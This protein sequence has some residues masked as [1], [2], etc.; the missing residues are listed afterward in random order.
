MSNS[1][2]PR[3]IA[4]TIVRNESSNYLR[5]W[6]ENIS[7]FADYH[8]F[9]DDASDDSTPDIIKEH[10]KKYPGELHI[11]KTPLFIKNEPLLRSELWDYTRRVARQGDWILIVDADE[12]YD[13]TLLRLK[14]KLLANKF[15]NIDVVKV[16]CLDMW[17]STSFRKDGYWSPFY[18]A[19][20]LIRFYDVDFGANNTSLHMPAYP[21]STDISKNL[22]KFVP[23]MHFAYLRSADRLRRYNF[24]KSNVS[25]D[26]N[27]TAYMHALS[28]MAPNPKTRSFFGVLSCIYH[29]MMGHKIYMQIY[30]ELKKYSQEDKNEKDS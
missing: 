25:P 3:L 14:P 18:T 19:V 6:L 15:P 23:M 26:E 13:E 27:K 11:R 1:Y 4:I 10:L 22:R 9:V 29:S 12:F 8:I 16:S 28:I 2:N 7:N 24:Y 20:R 5:S 17:N 21:S 30:K